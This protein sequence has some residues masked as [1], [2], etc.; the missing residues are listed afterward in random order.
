MNAKHPAFL[1]P[2]TDRAPRWRPLAAAAIAL[3]M[4]GALLPHSTHAAVVEH[5]DI[6]G[7]RTFQDTGTGRIWADLDNYYDLAGNLRFATYGSYIDALQN[8][9]FTWATGTPVYGL[10]NTL[11]LNAG[12]FG[13]YSAVMLTAFGENI[14]LIR[15]ITTLGPNSPW[16]GQIGN[17]SNANGWTGSATLSVSILNSTASV[18]RP[19]PNLG[20]IWAYMDT[21]VGNVPEPGSMAL[22]AAGLAALGMKRLR[23]A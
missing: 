2:H 19:Q 15:G 7:F 4:T 23:R 14:E 11:P 22:L 3:V 9:G 10:L 16:L 5:A 17:N 12:Q 6:A 13:S 20:G 8:A 21:P 18:D 1:H